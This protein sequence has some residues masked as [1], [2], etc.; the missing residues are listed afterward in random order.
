MTPETISLSAVVPTLSED[1]DEILCIITASQAK[2]GVMQ[3]VTFVDGHCV[4]HVR[5]SS[6]K[7]AGQS[8]SP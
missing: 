2:E 7:R 6:R 5:R 3:R 1:L 4:R 8:G